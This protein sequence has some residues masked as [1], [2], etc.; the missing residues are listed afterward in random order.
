MCPSHVEMLADR[1]YTGRAP[2]ASRPSLNTRGILSQVPLGVHN[3]RAF[4]L[5]DRIMPA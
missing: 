4:A 2:Q 3:G 5:K 1:T